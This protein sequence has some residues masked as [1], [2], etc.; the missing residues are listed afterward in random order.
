MTSNSADQERGDA[1]PS[2]SE[3][4]LPGR[5][6]ALEENEEFKRQA[7][8]GWDNIRERRRNREGADKPPPSS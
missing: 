6:R 2:E 1:G 4:Q 7:R 8:R 3:P 5:N